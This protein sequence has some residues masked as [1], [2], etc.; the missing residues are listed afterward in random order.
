[1]D[2]VVPPVFAR[3]R[4]GLRSGNCMRDGAR[5][6]NFIPSIS[7]PFYF[8]RPYKSTGMLAGSAYRRAGARAADRGKFFP[9]RSP[10]LS[11]AENDACPGIGAQELV[12]YLDLGYLVEGLTSA[13][14]WNNVVDVHILHRCDRVAHVVFLIVAR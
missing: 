3:F 4:E 13:V 8:G 2:E 7:L 10:C 12:G 11:G 14:Q 9:H 6:G 5:R 1:M